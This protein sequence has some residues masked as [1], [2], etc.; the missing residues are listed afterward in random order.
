VRRL[1]INADDF[2]L[3][4]GVNRAIV[5]AHENGVVSSA[6]LM[7]NGQAFAQAVSL[8][9]STPGLGVGCHVVLVD[10]AP[11]LPQ[12]QVHSL[13]DGSGNSAG[14]ARFREGIS[15]FGALAMLGRLAADEIE[16]EASAQIR[17]LQASGIPVTHLDSHKHTHLFPRVLR[18]LLRAAQRCGVRAIRNP[19]ERIQGSQLAASPSLWRRWAEVGV[20]QGFARQFREAVQQAGIATPD[21]TLAIVATGTLND[22]LLRLMV[23]NL[24]E[25][26][27]ELVCHPGYNDADLR[28]I[29]TRLRESR[30]QELRIL[31]SQSTRDLLAANGV[32]M[33]S[34]RD[35]AGAG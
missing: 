28:G 33:V 2:G 20:L 15:K 26:T 29:R 14:D 6:T 30:E 18:P 11:L 35:L 10:G 23:E 8:A 34:F 4:A 31:T 32:E 3:T 7:A 12:T 27:W 19:F 5:E 25:G 21:G 1:I 13:L 17:K 16:A 9:Q 24:P 22:R